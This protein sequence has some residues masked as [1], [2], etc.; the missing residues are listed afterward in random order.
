MAS[1][2]P[3]NP[4]WPANFDGSTITGKFVDILGNPVTGS[5]EFV[6]SAAALVNK[7][8]KII[9][10]PK[11]ITIP[12]SA[13][14][15]FTVTL[16][17][18]DDPDID[19]ENW[20]YKVTE[21]F[22]GGRTYNI[23]APQGQTVDLAEAGPVP[24]SAGTPIVVNTATPLV[25]YAPAQPSSII[26]QF[27]SGHGWTNTG[28]TNVNLNATDD[29]MKGT[30]SV[31]F[32][33]TS[34]AGFFLKR[35]GSAFDLT[36]KAFRITMKLVNRDALSN[37]IL[38][39]GN[40]G[41]TNAFRFRCNPRNTT[42]QS[43]G[44]NNEWFTFT[45]GWADLLDAQGSGY[46]VTNGV[47]STTT[48]FTD[49]ELN[50]SHSG[51]TALTGYVQSVELVPTAKAKYPN[52][53]VSIGFDDGWGSQV[54]A[55]PLMDAHGF[56]GT[57][58]LIADNVGT[59]GRLTHTDIKRMQ[60]N[61]WEIAGHAFTQQ[62]HDDRYISKTAAEVHAECRNLQRWLLDHKYEGTSFAYPG[63]EFDVTTDGVLVGDIVRDYFESGRSILFSTNVI[64]HFNSDQLPPAMP[65][66]MRSISG[67]SDSKAAGAADNPVFMAS[68]GGVL[69]RIA[70]T[71]GWLNLTF[72]EVLAGAGTNGMNIG[73]AA[74]NTLLDAIASRGMAV[75]PVQEVLRDYKI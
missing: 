29:Y 40:T 51:S 33:T 48:G 49:I 71:G 55:V 74:F 45:I 69:D 17:A 54:L 32:T 56:R 7:T 4:N 12:L 1:T 67:I 20:T 24:A 63:G 53:V 21:K 47:P 59:S 30:Q 46:T 5:I 44:V 11:T 41:L 26:T 23:A 50:V 13:T 39:V 35:S 37:I 19:P 61:G 22:T 36:N 27:Q 52:G 72:H 62:A 68:A 8:N 15:A 6:P 9:V 16:P 10:M 65:W 14:G 64:G 43:I 25:R 2:Y 18:T 31:K 34:G 38:R 42:T 3:S 70:Y 58:Y 60:F 57:Q 66:R 73:A 28:G 75:L